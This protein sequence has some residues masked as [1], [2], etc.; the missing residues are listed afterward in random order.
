V[1]AAGQPFRR[2]LQVGAH[3]E[4][5]DVHADDRGVVAL[6]RRCNGAFSGSNTTG[7]ACTVTSAPW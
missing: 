5:A 3:V 7:L 6:E 4:A 1:R 2:F